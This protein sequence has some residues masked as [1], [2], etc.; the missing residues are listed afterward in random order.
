MLILC[1]L[2]IYLRVFFFINIQK[3]NKTKKYLCKKK[4]QRNI[5]GKMIY[6]YTHTHLPTFILFYLLAYFSPI[7]M[8]GY[9]ETCAFGSLFHFVKIK[10]FNVYIRIRSSMSVNDLSSVHGNYTLLSALIFFVKSLL[11]WKRPPCFIPFSSLC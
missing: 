7:S 2:I 6:L 9:I 8:C 11:F 4:N 5:A 3:Q 1:E 10:I